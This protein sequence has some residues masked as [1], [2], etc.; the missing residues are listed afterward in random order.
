MLSDS[1]STSSEY[2]KQLSFVEL[3]T[4]GS[5]TV[6]SNISPISLMKTLKPK[7][8]RLSPWRTPL[9]KFN[10]LFEIRGYLFY[11]K[12]RIWIHILHNLVKI[13][14]CSRV[15]SFWNSPERQTVSN[16][17]E[18]SMIQAYNLLL[19]LNKYLLIIVLIYVWSVVLYPGLN[20]AWNLLYKSLFSMW[21][22]KRVRSS[23]VNS[24]PKQL[25]KL[26]QR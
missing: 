25:V 22:C 17:F 11:D 3:K 5:E 23:E 6:W 4:T 24:L 15:G 9:S 21:L 13:T 19:H 16:A 14:P 20:P 7:G 8:L 2:I 10:F 12:F 1:K 26:K 18:K